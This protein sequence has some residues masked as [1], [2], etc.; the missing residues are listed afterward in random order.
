MFYRIIFGI[1]SFSCPI[2]AI[3]VLEL[4]ILASYLAGLLVL[5]MVRFSAKEAML[6]SRSP[7]NTLF[8]EV[9]LFAVVAMEP[10]K[11]ENKTQFFLI[12]YNTSAEDVAK[13]GWSDAVTINIL[14]KKRPVCV[15]VCIGGGWQYVGEHMWH[16]QLKGPTLSILS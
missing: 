16:S 15:S 9:V 5:F 11:Q 1:F 6:L 8:V 2:Y 7:V 12:S 4:S 13:L 10:E 14:F 3:I